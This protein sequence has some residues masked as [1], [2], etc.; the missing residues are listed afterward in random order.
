M[1]RE[2]PTSCSCL[3]AWQRTPVI[4]ID[5]AVPTDNYEYHCT[6]TGDGQHDVLLVLCVLRCDVFCCA[7]LCC[8]MMCYTIMRFSVPWCYAVCC[9]ALYFDMVCCAFLCFSL[10]VLCYALLCMLCMLCC[11][12]M[13]SVVLCDGVPCCLLIFLFYRC[14]FFFVLRF[15][16]LYCST[17]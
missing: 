11:T 1:N 9:V 17:L 14:V 4:A 13:C 8:D 2:P 15:P 10:P 16:L 6:G 5:E 7:A 12:V 3:D